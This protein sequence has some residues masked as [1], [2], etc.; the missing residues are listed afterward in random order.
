VRERPCVTVV[1]SVHTDL[2]ASASTMPALGSSVIGDRFTLAPGGKAGN[3][4]AQLA[5]LDVPTVLVSRIGTDSL[6]NVIAGHLAAVGVDLS[7]LARPEEVAT[8]A[9]TVF[10]VGGE[11]ASIIVPGAAAG[12]TDND[13]ATAESAFLRSR[14][15]LTQLELGSALAMAVLSR[16]KALGATT[17][18]NASPIVGVHFDDLASMLELVDVLVVNRHEAAVLIEAP[19]AGR[20]DAKIAAVQLNERFG[21][22]VTVITCGADGNVLARE[23]VVIEQ[24]A[25]PVEVVDTVGAGDAFLGALIAAWQQGDDDRAALSSGAAAGAL[26]ASGS[27]A[28]TSLPNRSELNDYLQSRG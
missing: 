4:A 22:N 9:S 3:Q 19:I 8:G 7:C 11:Y 15:V 27:G 10:A 12:L 2:I 20:A 28:F 17:V 18:L 26:A 1:G 25:W 5:K 14:F 13:L 24:S 21:P 16:A 23:R 6:G